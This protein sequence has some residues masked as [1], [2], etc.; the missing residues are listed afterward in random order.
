MIAAGL[1]HDASEEWP[2]LYENKASKIRYCHY[3][4]EMSDVVF[5]TYKDGLKSWCAQQ[6]SKRVWH[7]TIKGSEWVVYVPFE[8]EQ[9][10]G[11]AKRFQQE[12]GGVLDNRPCN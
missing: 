6:S 12:L 3:G 4:P 11:V 7:P 2:S 8:N 9:T 1:C 5:I 10:K